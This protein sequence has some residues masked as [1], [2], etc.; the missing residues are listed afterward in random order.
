VANAR[1]HH[2]VIKEADHWREHI[3]VQE[4]SV[5]ARKATLEQQSS[6]EEVVGG[7]ADIGKSH[8]NSDDMIGCPQ[9]RVAGLADIDIMSRCR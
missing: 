8:K 7:Y 2:E 3:Q 4:R 5:K 6:G 9:L 1:S